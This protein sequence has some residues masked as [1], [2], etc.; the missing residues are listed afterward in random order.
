M[1][2]E[3][4]SCFNRSVALGLYILVKPSCTP[5]SAKR[6]YAK[7][8]AGAGRSVW[9]IQGR[10][11]QCLL[12]TATTIFMEDPDFSES[13]KGVN[14]N[15]LDKEPMMAVVGKFVVKCKLDSFFFKDDL[16]LPGVPF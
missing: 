12:G 15:P 3:I 14:G 8:I 4:P 10:C 1:P 9:S 16:E 5:D 13:V 2:G 11:D 6:L 7:T